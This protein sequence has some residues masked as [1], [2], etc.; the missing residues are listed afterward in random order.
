[1][2]LIFMMLADEFISDLSMQ[3][4]L[5]AISDPRKSAFIC[6]ICVPQ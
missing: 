3:L 2:T 5:E 1:M 4:G 6:V